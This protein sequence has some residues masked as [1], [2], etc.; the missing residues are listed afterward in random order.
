[1]LFS[2]LCLSF[3]LIDLFGFAVSMATLYFTWKTARNTRRIP[4]NIQSGILKDMPRH[5]YRNL[6]CTI[7]TILKY[8]EQGATKPYY[9]SESNVYRSQIPVDDFLQ[10]HED[11][12]VNM[13]EHEIKLYFRNYN[14]DVEGAAKH[15]GTKGVDDITLNG[16]YDNLLFKPLFL[17]K[18]THRLLVLMPDYNRRDSLRQSTIVSLV[19]THFNNFRKEFAL[20]NPREDKAK[21]GFKSI[22][23]YAD[24]LMTSRIEDSFTELVDVNG[25]FKNSLDIL[26]DGYSVS[27][28][29]RLFVD[30]DSGISINTDELMRCVMS[31]AREPG[32]KSFIEST[33]DVRNEYSFTHFIRNNNKH[34]WEEDDIN[35][36]FSRLQPYFQTLR[37]GQAD[38]YRLLLHMMCLDA[39]FQTRIIGMVNY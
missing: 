9:P 30:A 13:L 26:M 14:A 22:G 20:Y 11:E 38:L 23:Q 36:W 10:S 39:V 3:T 18:H 7:A 25:K 4:K 37:T 28:D 21:P 33:R 32:L 29:S 5:L 31:A 6:I 34:S 8:N 17:I 16:D 27:E 35:D 1:M 2:F 24:R 15:W 12:K 19:L